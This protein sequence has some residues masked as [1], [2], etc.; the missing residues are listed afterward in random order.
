MNKMKKFFIKAT[1]MICVIITILMTITPIQVSAKESTQVSQLY[2]TEDSKTITFIAD[3]TTS[4][5]GTAVKAVRI[6]IDGY[7][8]TTYKCVVTIPSGG[9][10]EKIIKGNNTEQIIWSS[11]FSYSGTFYIK[12]YTWSGSAGKTITAYC[13]LTR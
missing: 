5:N 2:I 8:D 3:A 4:M 10:Y 6:R 12:I 7:A 13:K 9:T 11:I 1:S